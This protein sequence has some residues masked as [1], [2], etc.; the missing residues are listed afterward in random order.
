MWDVL[1]GGKVMDNQAKSV[2]AARMTDTRVW[3]TPSSAFPGGAL[4]G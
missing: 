1:Y 2:S 3:S 4:A